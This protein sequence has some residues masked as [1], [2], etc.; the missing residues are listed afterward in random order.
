MK[1]WLT[2]VISVVVFMN[3]MVYAVEYTEQATSDSNTVAVGGAVYKQGMYRSDMLSNILV[4]A[5]IDYKMANQLVV[6]NNP[7]LKY[8]KVYRIGDV[9]RNNDDNPLVNENSTVYIQPVS[10]TLINAS[11]SPW[12]KSG[13]FVVL[14]IGAFFAGRVSN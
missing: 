3:S 1:Q 14:Y 10:G 8:Y 12:V 5:G 4:K 6:V 2:V 13:V 11:M 9:M 7:K